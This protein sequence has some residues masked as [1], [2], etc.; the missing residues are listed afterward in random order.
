MGVIKYTIERGSGDFLTKNDV[1]ENHMK[2][3]QTN[4]GKTLGMD[5]IKKMEDDYR[6]QVEEL[7]QLQESTEEHERELS[8]MREKLEITSREMIER[9]NRELAVREKKLRNEMQRRQ[10]EQEEAYA[11]R[12]KQLRQERERLD[13]DDSDNDGSDDDDYDSSSSSSSS[14]DDDDDDDF[15]MELARLPYHSNGRRTVRRGD[16]RRRATVGIPYE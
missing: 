5:L 10:R 4:A 1:Y 15:N 12:E 6:Q 16:D 7:R 8:R 9:M 13:D 3:S 11:W 14:D 2:L